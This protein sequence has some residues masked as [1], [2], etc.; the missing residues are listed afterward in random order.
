MFYVF[1]FSLIAISLVI[2]VLWR[3]GHPTVS[4]DPAPHHHTGTE[5]ASQTHAGSAERHE[6]QRRRNQSKQARRKRR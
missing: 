6:R 3:R 4:P 1:I 5:H 2:V